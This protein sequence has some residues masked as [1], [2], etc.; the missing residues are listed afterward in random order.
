[1]GVI[2]YGMF[3]YIQ[4]TRGEDA[5]YTRPAIHRIE[6]RRGCVYAGLNIRGVDIVIVQGER[7]QRN[8]GCI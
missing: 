7:V 6:Y 2:E 3:E 1:M 8:K 5:M 4:C